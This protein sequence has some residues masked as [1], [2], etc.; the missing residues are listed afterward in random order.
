MRD[1]DG[2]NEHLQV[3]D[4]PIE[5]EFNGQVNTI[6]PSLIVYQDELILVDAGYPGFLD[7]IEGEMLKKGYS[8]DRLTQIIITHYDEDHIG[9][10][11]AFKEK[12]PNIKIIASKA[13]SRAIS[14]EVKSERLRQA[15]Q[16]LEHMTEQ[17]KE[18]GIWFI[19]QLKKLKAVP[20]DIIVS[21]GDRLLDGQCEVISTPG[22]T[23]GHISL[24]FPEQKSV[25]TGDAA[26]MENEELAVANPEFC[27]D[28]ASAQQSLNLIKTLDANT[29]YCY[30]GGVY[31]R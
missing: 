5:F 20:V 21:G 10:L 28:I 22:H 12:H 27:L 19:G 3:I 25:V 30:H 1:T 6:C 15:E 11:Y 26:V 14:G 13:E 4:L 18:F 31:T 17:D 16:M 2:V 7:R 9:S 24:Y 29:Y 23:A 8:P